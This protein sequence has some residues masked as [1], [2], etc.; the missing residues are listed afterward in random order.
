MGREPTSRALDDDV[1]KD[2]LTQNPIGHFHYML[3][4]TFERRDW[5]LALREFEQSRRAAPSND[6]LF[7]NLGLHRNGWPPEALE[8]FERARSLGPRH[9]ASAQRAV[10]GEKVDALR[11]E[12]VESGAL[13]R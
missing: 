2:H 6:M 8:R 4:V 7:C 11:A 13:P 1:P 9:L 12:L 10:P 5:P 3:G